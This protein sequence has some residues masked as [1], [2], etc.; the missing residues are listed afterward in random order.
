[1]LCV[2][3][4]AAI[5]CQRKVDLEYG[6]ILEFASG[7][8]LLR[9]SLAYDDDHRLLRFQRSPYWEKN[10]EDHLLPLIGKETVFVDGGAAFGYYSIL[11]HNAGAYVHAYNP[12]PTFVKNMNE[13]LNINNVSSR[14]C[15]HNKALGDQKG[16]THIEYG[17][18]R[19]IGKKGELV[20]ITTLDTLEHV[21]V[22]KLDI[23]GNAGNALRGATQLIA[24]HSTVWFIALHN[25]IERT[26]VYALLAGYNITRI[27]TIPN[28]MIMASWLFTPVQ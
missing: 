19:G 20:E 8:K 13:N 23:E 24:A 22:V 3:L 7:V 28:E 12:H 6:T 27:E 1:M 5:A 9:Y 25:D 17:T 4:V 14:V 10:V 2:V 18:G 21:D 26:D 11:A 15:V 16:T